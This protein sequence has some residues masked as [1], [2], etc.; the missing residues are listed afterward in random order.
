MGGRGMNWPEEISGTIYRDKEEWLSFEQ[1][2]L[3]LHR[4]MARCHHSR[5]KHRMVMKIW[6]EEGEE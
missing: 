6:D 3:F 2:D 1:H 4:I 5:V